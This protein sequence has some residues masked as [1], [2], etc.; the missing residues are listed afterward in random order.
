MAT[1]RHGKIWGLDDTG[2]VGST[3][4][5]AFAASLNNEPRFAVTID[6]P[7]DLVCTATVSGVACDS[8]DFRADV[9]FGDGTFRA[10]PDELISIYPNPIAGALA[11]YVVIVHVPWSCELRLMARRVGG[12]A[13][14]LLNVVA[15][16]R[17][18]SGGSLLGGLASGAMAASGVVA[19]LASVTMTGAFQYTGAF[20]ASAYNLAM[21]LI[22]KTTVNVPTNLDIDVQLSEDAGATW[23]S[24]DQINT[25]AAGFDTRSN[26]IIRKTD[27]GAANPENHVER[28]EIVP[29]FTYRIG[30]RFI[31]GAAPDVAL[32]VILVQR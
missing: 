5:V 32:D 16:A 21:V 12:A 13:T 29:H 26:S 14:A 15:D 23:R 8:V 19:Q 6:G 18:A 4:D 17:D 11:D 30:A 2:D 3:L 7:T 31:G 20:A 1:F 10:L 28:V 24:H 25:V 27:V 9:T 22:D